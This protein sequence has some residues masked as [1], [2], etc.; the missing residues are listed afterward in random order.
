MLRNV[1]D[2]SNGK[3]HNGEAAKILKSAELSGRLKMMTAIRVDGIRGGW[4]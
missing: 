2:G 3:G 1:S 4:R